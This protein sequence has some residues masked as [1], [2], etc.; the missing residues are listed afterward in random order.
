MMFF[1]VYHGNRFAVTDRL[2]RLIDAKMQKKEIDII[3]TGFESIYRNV[4]Q[5]ARVRT[6]KMRNSIEV[7]VTEKGGQISVGAYYSRFIE[8]GTEHNRAFPFFFANVHAG[9]EIIIEQ[10]KVTYGILGMR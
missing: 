1:S 8:K 2:E 10:I 3:R 6:G 7:T 4:Y 9:V 5:D